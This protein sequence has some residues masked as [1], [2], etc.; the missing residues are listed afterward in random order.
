I[1]TLP[2]IPTIYYG[3]EQGYTGQ[4]DAM[5]AGG[6]GA[7]GRDRFDRSAPLYRYLQGAIALRR[8]HR[9]FSRGMPTVLASNAAAP[10]ALAWRMA[11]EGESA[12]VVLNTSDEETLLDNLDTGIAPGTVLEGL[13]GIDGTPGDL[14]V[15]ADGRATL[16]LAPRAGLVWKAS[17]SVVAPQAAAASITLSPESGGIHDA[18]FTVGGTS[19]GLQ[20]FRLVVDG[21]LA[22]ARIVRPDAEGRWQA[23]V[24]T[25]DMVDAS[26]A[27][28]LVAWSAAPYAV[29]A[30]QEIGRAACRESGRMA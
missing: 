5:F 22:G 12:L 9:V 23:E 15:G 8:E 13:F 11:W 19:E 29:S 6:Y 14:G 18:D 20:S 25:G 7:G 28:R 17:D 24:E 26:I 4:R 1:L 16:R 27:H 3:T 21:D 30:G 2:G 10:G